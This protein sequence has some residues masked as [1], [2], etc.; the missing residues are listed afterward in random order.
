MKPEQKK[1]LGSGQTGKVYK[2]SWMGL[3]SA[4]KVMKVQQ[5]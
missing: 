4:T 5:K 3:Q 2:S 1:N